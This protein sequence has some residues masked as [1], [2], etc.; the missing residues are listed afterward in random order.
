MLLLLIILA[1]R[2]GHRGGSLRCPNKSLGFAFII[3]ELEA[4]ES[5]ILPGISLKILYLKKQHN[6]EMIKAE[7]RRI[8]S[9]LSLSLNSFMVH[10]CKAVYLGPTSVN[11][12]VDAVKIYY[13]QAHPSFSP[14]A[15]E[16]AA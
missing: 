5:V 6:F 13:L 2:L 8:A 14:G 9:D 11:V 1:S 3:L 16:K 15:T 12:H 4:N 10:Y 7:E